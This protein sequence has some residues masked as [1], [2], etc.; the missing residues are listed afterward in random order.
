M[1][2]KKTTDEMELAKSTAQKRARSQGMMVACFAWLAI[3]FVGPLFGYL[4]MH[5]RVISAGDEEYWPRV[6][7]FAV[8]AV[9]GSLMIFG[10]VKK[11]AVSSFFSLAICPKCGIANAREIGK[12]CACGAE[13][14]PLCEM[15][16]VEDE[17]TQSL[18]T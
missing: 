12:Q 8:M 17:N 2:V 11:R 14:V 6:P 1:W 15:K 7:V 9:F 3:T 18:K 10:I 5:T 4:G 16:W 13:F